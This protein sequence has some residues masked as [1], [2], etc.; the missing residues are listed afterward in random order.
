MDR[1]LGRITNE[2]PAAVTAAQRD[3]AVVKGATWLEKTAGGMRRV[4]Y[5]SKHAADQ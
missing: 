5:L 2:A 3:G 1:L 4:V